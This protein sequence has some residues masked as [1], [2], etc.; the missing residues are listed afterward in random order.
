MKSIKQKYTGMKKDALR[1]AHAE[2]EAAFLK[3]RMSLRDNP[4]AHAQLYKLRY[5]RALIKTLL[6]N[7]DLS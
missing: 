2:L 7:P 4:K 3:S 6:Q 5:E 1:K